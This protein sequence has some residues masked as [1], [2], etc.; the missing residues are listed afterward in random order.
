MLTH[1]LDTLKAM[2][3]TE[4][5]CDIDAENF[6][7]LVM[8]VRSIAVTRPQNLHKFAEQHSTK[9]IDENSSK[10]FCNHNKY[11]FHIISRTHN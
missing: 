5:P 1:V 8:I 4:D 7:R 6:Y 10:N 3:E 2:R 11:V 9:P